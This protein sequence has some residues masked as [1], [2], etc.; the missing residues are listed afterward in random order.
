MTA[1]EAIS[2][3]CGFESDDE[4]VMEITEKASLSQQVVHYLLRQIFESKLH[5]N[6]ISNVY[7][8]TSPPFAIHNDLPS[9]R[10][11]LERSSR[12]LDSDNKTRFLMSLRAL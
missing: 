12:T 9:I 6:Y 8:D 2:A 7:L 11:S 5:C 3:G 1:V 4:E 10:S